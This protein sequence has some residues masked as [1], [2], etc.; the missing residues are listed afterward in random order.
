MCDEDLVCRGVAFLNLTPM[1][2]FVAGGGGAVGEATR[3]ELN[4]RLCEILC[5]VFQLS[6]LHM[7]PAACWLAQQEGAWCSSHQFNG[8]V[9]A[10][11]RLLWSMIGKIR[12]PPRAILDKRASHF[13]T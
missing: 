7:E 2:F 8:S 12:R 11:G 1:A 13:G 6:D 3:S 9:P 4:P 5:T 10:A